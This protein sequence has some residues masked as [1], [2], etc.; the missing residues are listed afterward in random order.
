MTRMSSR[1]IITFIVLLACTVGQAAA[2]GRKHAL[3][4]GVG[5]YASADVPQLEG[6]GNDVAALR[7][8]LVGQLGFEPGDVRTLVDAQAT[9]VAIMTQLVELSRR[10]KAGDT[11]MIYFSGHGTSALDA[12]F[13]VPVPHGSG[14][15]AP[16]DLDLKAKNPEKT[17]IVGRADLRPV[18][19]E[20]DAK[21]RFVL[22]VSD[23]C[24]SGQQVR[25]MH[26][27]LGELPSRMIGMPSRDDLQSLELARQ[28][29]G[30][31]NDQALVW[32]YKNVVFLSA[33]AEGERAKDIPQAFVSRYATIDGK[34][35]GAMTDALLR[36]LGAPATADFDGN[37]NVSG[38][39]LH[40]AVARFMAG[41]AYG[42]APQRLPSVTEDVAGAASRSLFASGA[43]KARA[44]PLAEPVRFKVAAGLPPNIESA[45]AGFPGITLVRDGQGFGLAPAANKDLLQITTPTGD[46]VTT[47][48]LGDTQRLLGQ[49]A[50]LA[51]AHQLDTVAL[52]GSRAA[53]Q[54][55][56]TPSTLGG[57]FLIGDTL[58]FVVRPDR[59][60]KLLVV[61]IDSLGKVSVLYP[62]GRADLAPIGANA[63][64]HIPGE[65]P[66]QRIKVTEPLG[67]DVQFVFAFDA[68]GPDLSGWINVLDVPPG[69]PR[70]G[71]LM[72]LVER[73]RGKYAYART[74]IRV[75]ERK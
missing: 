36:V 13:D 71:R 70:L 3:L 24:Y 21:G 33:S 25:S 56:I 28:R 43:T 61:N 46:R 47:L 14:A 51:W 66:H 73:Q 38:H 50:Q 60:S 41:R 65:A 59:A 63:L 45:L 4:V 2:Q 11:V 35:H 26:A 16:Y 18:L 6:P 10:S 54:A 62:F 31:G 12:G 17:L 39:E 32:P 42:H 7:Q 1:K 48:P 58:A 69:D 34:A 29:A 20:L 74:E 5:N 52:R 64:R 55:E 8:V 23:S 67:Q 49:V 53:L 57:N 22:F 72:E 44:S 15:F 75:L 9:R 30:R 19:E 40:H 68:D 37:G 27:T